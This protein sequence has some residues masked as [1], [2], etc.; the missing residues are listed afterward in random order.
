MKHHNLVL[1][2]FDVQNVLNPELLQL[3][4]LC[5]HDQ[6]SQ[7]VLLKGVARDCMSQLWQLLV[8]GNRLGVVWLEGHTD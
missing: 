2:H 3:G 5:R 6:I 8:C 7:S 4:V 1:E